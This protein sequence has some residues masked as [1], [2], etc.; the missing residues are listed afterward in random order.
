LL[1]GVALAYGR[2]ALDRRLREPT[3]VEALLEQPVVGIVRGEALGRT[4]GGRNGTATLSPEDEEPFR[5]MRQNVRYLT[6]DPLRSMLVTSA[7]PSEGK[8]TVAICLAAATAAAGK[9]TLLVECDLRRPTLAARLGL[10]T[11]PGLT[12]YLTQ[13]ADWKEVACSVPTLDHGAR[14]GRAAPD[15]V[16]GYTAAGPLNCIT[17]GSHAPRPTELLGSERFRKF[18][19]EV[20]EVYDA[21]IIDSAPLLSAADTLEIVPLVEGILICVRLRQTTREQASGLRAALERLPQRPTGLIL[22]GV[23][24][25]EPG[26]YGYYGHYRA[27][28]PRSEPAQP[29]A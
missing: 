5:V 19:V 2:D 27:G 23:Q 21:V 17:A 14:N 7:M 15:S 28:D 29:R 16:A 6:P 22:T 10:R 24:K 12:D 3:D 13:H 25:T 20:C 4:F 26:Y 8:T 9:R 1:L 11:V 18:L